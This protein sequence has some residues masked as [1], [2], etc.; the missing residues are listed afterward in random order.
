MQSQSV[1]KPRMVKSRLPQLNPQNNISQFVPALLASALL[2]GIP[3]A[4]ICPSYAQTA[5]ARPVTPIAAT[6]PTA[7]PALVPY[8]GEAVGSDGTVLTGETSITFQVFK[9]EQGGEPLFVETQSVALDPTG[10]YKVQLGASMTSGIPIQLF[11]SGEARWLEVQV[12]GQASKPRVLLVSVPYAF[13]AADAA[14]LG[15]LPAS[16]YALAGNKAAVASPAGV[17]PNADSAVT[18]TG[19]TAGYIPDFSG[20]ATIVDSPI[21]VT[22]GGNVGVGTTT[23]ADNFVVEGTTKLVGTTRLD[24]ELTSVAPVFLEPT[25]TATETVGQPSQ[26]LKFQ[27]SAYD[28]SANEA[29]PQTFAWQ[30]L[31]VNN[32]TATAGGV[33]DLLFATGAN[34]LA[35]TGLSV[36]GNGVVS[37][38]AG[39]T[40]PGTIKEVTAGT[41]LTG[42]GTTGTVILNVDT[43]KVPLLASANTFTKPITFAAGQTFPG[44]GS[45]TKVTAGSGL[46]GGG[47]NG[48]VTLAID[49]TKIPTLTDN[50]TFTSTV[51]ASVGTGTAAFFASNPPEAASVYV[52]N[53]AIN[54]G[55]G[56]PPY[57]LVSRAANGVSVFGGSVDYTAVEGSLN[58]PSTVGNDFNEGAGVWGDA[59]NNIAVLGTSDGNI[60]GAFINN[61]D[62][63]TVVIGNNYSSDSTALVLQT[64]GP[65]YNGYCTIDVSGNLSCNGTVSAIAPV[66]HGARE[67]QTYSMQSAE[68]WLEDAGTGQLA[69]GLAH[70]DLDPVFGQ[71]VNTAVDYHVFLTPNGDC[72]G[73]YVGAKSA[74]GFEVRELG[75]GH[76]TIA[77]DFRIMAKRNG[78]ENVRLNDVTERLK[79]NA[80]PRAT[81]KRPVVAQGRSAAH[82]PVIPSLRPRIPQPVQPELIP[83]AAKVAPN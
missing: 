60:A 31:P 56:N 82:G 27:A 16:A 83:T 61:A 62:G 53:N 47:S 33:L 32:D 66:D 28:K 20:A 55:T 19:G 22:T 40:F 63:P 3:F 78:Y 50:P 77:F 49:T 18:T 71:T 9:D 67:V 70:V 12:A 4:G 6:A 65:N 51:T 52:V 26:Q 74:N 80:A 35:P 8:S 43:T 10:R 7:V 69:N 81:I 42:G 11:S 1:S 45:I 25:T 76:S 48:N 59:V 34:T 29:V 23:P 37:F 17:T 75:G 57:G 13:K 44:T 68:N 38:A 24:G 58:G 14:T 36:A 54:D 30:A 41:A 5:I 64:E 73:L 79:K 2:A 72:K 21:F 15:G 39:Q 46:I